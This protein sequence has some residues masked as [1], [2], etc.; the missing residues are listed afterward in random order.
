MW[1][2]TYNSILFS[3]KD[4]VKDGSGRKVDATGNHYVKQNKL[5][6]NTNIVYFLLYTG[7]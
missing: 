3:F 2:I 6:K 4:K 5:F 7:F 1:Q